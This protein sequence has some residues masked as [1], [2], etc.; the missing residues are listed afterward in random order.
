MKIP[1]LKE[2]AVI[3]RMKVS[4]VTPGSYPLP[5]A[6]SSSVE[7]VVEHVAGHVASYTDT[8]IYGRSAP[9]LARRSMV[10]EA[11]CVR[12]PAA[13]KKR[14]I[15]AVARSLQAFRPDVVVVENRPSYVLSV[16]KRS[17]G[18]RIWLSLHSSTFIRSPYMSLKRLKLCIRHAERVI[19]NSNFLRDVVAA[20]VPEAAYKIHV[21]HLGVETQRF[22]SQYSAEGAARRYML[23]AK[24]GWQG[25]S[26]VLF[27]GRLIP[28]KGVH[29][30]LYL[31][32]EL[33]ARHPQLLLVI[34]GSAF[35]GS[36]RMTAYSRQLHRLGKR[37]KE[38]I[39]FVPYVPYT[40][41]PDWFLAADIAVVPSGR[42]EAF[43][44][45]NVEAMSC[46]LPVVATRVGGIKEIVEHGG[47]GFLVEPDA[48]RTELKQRLLQL[49]ENEQ[50][51]TAM[52]LRSR[53]RV[54][55]LFTW[56]RTGD[57]WV[58]LLREGGR[59]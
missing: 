18:A 47:T 36:H 2:V 49:L 17:P 25:R 3:T 52:G 29:H 53:E 27:M 19:V 38:H 8:R 55:E 11:L 13:D 57:Q 32:P 10:K 22:P 5:S 56:S 9:K 26:I 39:C 59:R 40:Q 37:W 51:R 12:F 1:I 15:A 6:K 30:L 41:V 20:R 46:G 28:L 48:V 7:R 35:Y 54:E 21:I 58:Q 34:V 42:R 44:L 4:F 43:G 33:V 50:L 31:L 23:R 14:Y 24:R 16:R 45:V